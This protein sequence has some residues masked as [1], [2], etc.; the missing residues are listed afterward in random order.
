MSQENVEVVRGWLDAWESW[1]NSERDPDRLARI[2]SQYL[3]P[4]VIYEEDPVWPDAGIFR[5]REAVSRRFRDYIDLVHLHR[6]SPG[7]VIDAPD[8]VLAEVRISILGTGA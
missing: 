4:E 6:V 2:A 5:G 8:L 7:E 1:F 3:T